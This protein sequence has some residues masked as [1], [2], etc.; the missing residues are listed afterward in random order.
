MDECKPLIVGLRG[1]AYLNGRKGVH[2]CVDPTNSERAII[3]LFPDGTVVS[4]VLHPRLT[5]HI[6][7]SRTST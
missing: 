2:Q 7:N 3:A 6:Y 5:L 1:A 4:A